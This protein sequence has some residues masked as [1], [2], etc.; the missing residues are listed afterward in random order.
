MLRVVIDPGVLVSARLSG[1]GA[2]AEMIRR[3]LAGEIDI[4][5]SPLL[6]AEL[7]DVLTR[8]KFRRWLSVA[9]ADAYTAFLASHATVV[10]DPHPESGHTPDPDDDYLVTLARHARA[11]VLV[12]GDSDLCGLTDPHPPVRT[13]R[14]LVE[15]LDRIDNDT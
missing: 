2:P 12:S 9:E 10:D 7:G 11:D 14:A 3:W 1:R 13:P 8:P 15:A 4:I 5:V 6:L